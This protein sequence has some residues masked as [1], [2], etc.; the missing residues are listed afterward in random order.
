VQPKTSY[1]PSTVKL[2]YYNILSSPIIHQLFRPL[3]LLSI[4]SIILLIST[5][6]LNLAFNSL[7]TSNNLLAFKPGISAYAEDSANNIGNSYMNFGD[8]INLSN[9]ARDSVYAQIAV[10]GNNVYVVW[11]EETPNNKGNSVT[12]GSTNYDVYFK[13]TTDGGVTFSKAINISNNSGFSQ[14][15]QIAVSGGNVYIA[16]TDDTSLNKEILFRMSSDEGNSFGRTIKLSNDLGESYNQE[17]SA[18]ANNVYVVWENKYSNPDFIKNTGSTN[19]SGNNND[20][21]SV[22][23]LGGTDTANNN[24]GRILFKSSMDRG[25]SFKNTKIITTN[26]GGIAESYPKIAASENNVYLAWNIGMPPSTLKEGR[27][28]YYNNYNNDNGNKN[29]TEQKHGIFFTKS[30][31]TGDNFSKIVKLN[32]DAS[33]IGE[34]QIAA[35]GNQV[36]IVWSGNSDNLIPNDLFFIKSVD[37]G[38]SFTEESSLRKKSSLNAELAMDGDNVYIVWQDFLRSNNQEI[39]IKKS[40][41]RGDTFADTTTNISNNEGTSECP[42]IAIS[43]N[44]VYTIWEDD[45]LGNH[46]IF[47][48]R[49]NNYTLP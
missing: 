20:I 42:S 47:F 30:S 31:D 18:F 4:F 17:I 28:N 37:N 12:H 5:T 6:A 11:E 43:K 29:V 24:N 10:Y 19:A 34:S 15:P 41:D 35:S 26:S 21:N 27:S 46:E 32:N 9:N 16:W 49:S 38:N 40:I 23:Q 45:T 48:A 22:T 33:H 25:N 14:H 3:Y 44:I 36:F 39:L 8:P 13:K 7:V 1:I 2:K